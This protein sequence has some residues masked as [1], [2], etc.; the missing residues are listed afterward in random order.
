MNRYASDERRSVTEGGMSQQMFLIASV[1][2]QSEPVAVVAVV[3]A[4]WLVSSPKRLVGFVVAVVTFLVAFAV[5]GLTA[6]VLEVTR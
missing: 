6:M 3:L 1:S 2:S 5:A 4:L